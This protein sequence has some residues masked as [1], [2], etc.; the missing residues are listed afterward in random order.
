MIEYCTNQYNEEPMNWPFAQA[1]MSAASDVGYLN[2]MPL[3]G[4]YL[5]ALYD[6]VSMWQSR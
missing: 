3:N 6:F 5:K 2:K 1:G 4:E